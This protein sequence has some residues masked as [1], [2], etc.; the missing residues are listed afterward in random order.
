[1]R[2]LLRLSSMDKAEEQ[3]A[4]LVRWRKKKSN[5]RTMYVSI[6]CRLEV[7]TKT[8][9]FRK[10]GIGTRYA[11]PTHNTVSQVVS[12][13]QALIFHFIQRISVF[14]TAHCLQKSS[15]LSVTP[16]IQIS[17]NTS[18]AHPL[19]DR[20]RPCIPNLKA[21]ASLALHQRMQTSMSVR[22]YTDENGSSGDM[23]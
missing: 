16:Q 21:A 14:I 12:T 8:H 22:R 19:L 3:S 1:M 2:C 6:G 17:N 7:K 9:N 20:R 4:M 11:H 18:S 5:A 10:K 15:R 23:R 13:S